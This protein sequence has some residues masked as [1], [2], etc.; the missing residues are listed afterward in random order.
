MGYDKFGE[1]KKEISFSKAGHL[2]DA[3][4][5]L[6]DV[7]SSAMFHLCHVTVYEQRAV[8]RPHWQWEGLHAPDGTGTGWTEGRTP[9]ETKS[10]ISPRN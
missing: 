2:S 7:E 3:G 9:W 1:K 6:G 4:W 8:L 10:S 5:F